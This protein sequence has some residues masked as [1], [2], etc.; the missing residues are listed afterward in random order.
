MNVLVIFL[1][2]E[3]I[4]LEYMKKYCCQR[5]NRRASFSKIEA[6]SDD[7]Y[8]EIHCEFLINEYERCKFDKVHYHEL[9]EKHKDNANF[10]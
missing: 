6:I 10:E 5:W 4:I 8:E 9:I 1:L 7:Y 3:S 2:F